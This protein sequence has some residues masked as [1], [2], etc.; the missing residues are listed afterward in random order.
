MHLGACS[1]RQFRCVLYQNRGTF[2]EITT[3]VKL[4]IDSQPGLRIETQTASSKRQPMTRI[5][6]AKAQ[7]CENEVVC[8]FYFENESRSMKDLA[9]FSHLKCIN[10]QIP[11][12]FVLL[13]IP[14]VS[15]VSISLVPCIQICK[16]NIESSLSQNILLSA[17]ST[18]YNTTDYTP[19]RPISPHLTPPIY[20]P[21]EIHDS[22][23]V[24]SSS[25]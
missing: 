22:K 11:R 5:I 21:Y 8:E 17:T 19:S 24:L 20:G 10:V 18:T 2:C 23:T 9:T 1:L 15:P 4:Q 14:L 16:L 12:E 6:R 25:E 7:L 13:T 3:K